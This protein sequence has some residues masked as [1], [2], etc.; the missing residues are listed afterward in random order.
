MPTNIVTFQRRSLK[1]PFEWESSEVHFSHTKFH[2][3]TNGK[4]EEG[5]GMLQVDFANRFVGGGV[6]GYGCVQEEI[7]F[8][9]NPE[10]IVA[11]L[12]TEC[13]G[14]VEALIMIGCEQ[15]NAYN[16]YANT[17]RW[18]G[19]FQDSTPL[20][21]YRRRKC[22]IVAIDALS[23]KND[24]EQFKEEKFRRELSKAYAGFYSDGPNDKEPV[25]TGM[26]S[27]GAFKGHKIKSA[28]IQIMVCAVAHRNIVFFTV[29]D[30]LV[31]NEVAEVYKFL[32]ENDVSVGLLYRTLRKYRFDG[33]PNHLVRFIKK[34]ITSAATNIKPQVKHVNRPQNNV[35]QTSMFNFVIPS[36][37]SYTLS[38]QPKHE[39]DVQQ[40]TLEH[41]SCSSSRGYRDNQKFKEIENRFVMKKSTESTE[42]PKKMSLIDSLDMTFDLEMSSSKTASKTN[43]DG[44]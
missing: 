18:G 15:F 10:M 27:C 29:G 24:Y 38:S 21:T 30:D 35:K 23:Y 2:I 11:R 4:I 17:F 14:D 13:L 39:D 1:V 34:E 36:S 25:A 22:R 9:I 41:A 28:L 20:D 43:F 37:T 42:N 5:N 6:L 40:S 32:V 33:Q 26:W 31:R 44:F 19:N 12:F 7:R 16:G 3:T 8:V